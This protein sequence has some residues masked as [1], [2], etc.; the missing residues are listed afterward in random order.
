[1][2]ELGT[3]RVILGVGKQNI[4]FVIIEKLLQISVSPIKII[5]NDMDYSNM[6]FCS[7]SDS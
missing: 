1:M 4:Y 2:Y 3:N 6:N 7:L 5:N